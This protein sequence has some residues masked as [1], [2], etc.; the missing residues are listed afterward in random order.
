MGRL[1][2]AGLTSVVL[3]IRSGVYKSSSIKHLYQPAGAK[4]NQKLKIRAKQLKKFRNSVYRNLDFL[5]LNR[6]CVNQNVDDSG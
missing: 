2:C 3:R 4:P 1:F 5:I 6:H